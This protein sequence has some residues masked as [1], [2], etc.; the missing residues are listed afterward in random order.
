VLAL[1]L[2]SEIIGQMAA[3]MV[4]S[5]QPERLRIVNLQR[6]QIKDALDAEVTP[7]DVVAEEEIPSLGRVAAD[8]EE[9]HQIEVLPVDIPAHRDRCVHLQEV[10]FC[11]QKL[12]ALP[13][14]P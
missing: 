13:D 8:L 2:E 4:S 6:P 9:L 10:R 11:S 1:E 7:V 14:D 5:Q 12:G 3:L